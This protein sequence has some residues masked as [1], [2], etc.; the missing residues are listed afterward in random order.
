MIRYEEFRGFTEIHRTH[1]WLIDGWPDFTA[2]FMSTK[3]QSDGFGT[4]VCT[5]SA[6]GRLSGAADLWDRR[7]NSFVDNKV[8]DLKLNQ[9]IIGLSKKKKTLANLAQ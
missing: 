9:T 4:K 5:V 1:G 2:S 8:S 6:H 7:I 3:D